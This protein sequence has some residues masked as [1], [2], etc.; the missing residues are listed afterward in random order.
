MFF[1]LGERVLDQGEG[2]QHKFHMTGSRR[3][4][5]PVFSRCSLQN[6]L[7]GKLIAF[8]E[9]DSRRAKR[10]EIDFSWTFSPGESMQDNT[11]NVQQFYGHVFCITHRYFSRSTLLN[12][13]TRSPIW[14]AICSCVAPCQ[15]CSCVAVLLRCCVCQ[16]RPF[17]RNL[18]VLLRPSGSKGGE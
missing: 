2:V 17:V 4:G 5:L 8:K 10:I 11:G 18:P 3:G 13:H 1:L 12:V 7:V 16:P 15:P 14:S 6:N 9:V